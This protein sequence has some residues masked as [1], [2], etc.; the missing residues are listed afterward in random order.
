MKD[1]LTVAILIVAG[2]VAVTFVPW[3]GGGLATGEEAPAFSLASMDGGEPVDLK[4]HL[5]K[6]V[7]VLDFFATWCP[8][9]REG[10]PKLAAVEEAFA[11]RN[12]QFYA[13]NQGE[14]AETVSAMWEKEGFDLSVLLDRDGSVGEAYKVTG[15]P[16]TVVIAP[17]GQVVH[18]QS[19]LG[20]SFE[21]TLTDA[22]EQ[23]LEMS[24][25]QSAP[26]T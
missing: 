6:D 10:L 26:A 21:K 1:M 18:Y 13:V 20:F 16:T 12:V 9:C 7:L 2:L 23:A 19:G 4:Q 25:G 24:A 22:I 3:S 5:G 14:T 15:I 11:D 17:N 8:P